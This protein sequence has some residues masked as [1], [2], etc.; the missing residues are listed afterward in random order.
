MASSPAPAPGAAPRTPPPAELARLEAALSAVVRWSESKYTRAEVARLSGCDVP[1][2]ALRLLEHFDVAGAMRVSDIADCLRIDISTVSLQLRR[3]K[4]DGLVSRLPDPAD[5]RS[6]VIAITSQ[7]R[8]ALARVRAARCELLA[9][10]FA[11]AAPEELGR[12][13]DTLLR[14]Q[15][16]ML[17]AMAEA[18]YG[19]PLA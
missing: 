3:L 8:D 18:G 15:E 4:A 17:A 12:A 5:A 16:H 10:A 2:S 13:A 9:G 19:D 1:P 11:P 14:V 7:G 6:G